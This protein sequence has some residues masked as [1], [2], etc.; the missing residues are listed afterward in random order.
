MLKWMPEI[1]SLHLHYVNM[2]D[3]YDSNMPKYHNV[4]KTFIIMLSIVCSP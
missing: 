4:Y 3:N 2:P 1:F